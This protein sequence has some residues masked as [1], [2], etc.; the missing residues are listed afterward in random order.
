MNISVGYTKLHELVYTRKGMYGILWYS[1]VYKRVSPRWAG[2]GL[3]LR[4]WN[5]RSGRG[6]RQIEA[7]NATVPPGGSMVR[8]VEQKI[9]NRP[10][11]LHPTQSFI[12]YQ[13]L[14]GWNK[15]PNGA[16]YRYTTQSCEPV[17]PPRASFLCHSTPARLWGKRSRGYGSNSK[18]QQSQPSLFA[19]TAIA[20]ALSR[21]LYFHL[22]PSGLLLIACQRSFWPYCSATESM[23]RNLRALHPPRCSTVAQQNVKNIIPK[24]R[25]AQ[26]RQK[27]G[28]S[29]ISEGRR[30][31]PTALWYEDPAARTYSITQM[32]PVP[33]NRVKYFWKINTRGTSSTRSIS[34]FD[35]AS[36]AS[37]PSISG[38]Y[39]FGFFHT[40][41][42][43]GFDT[44]WLLRV[45]EVFWGSI[46][47]NTACTW[48][49]SKS[50]TDHTFEYLQYQNSL[51]NRS[52]LGVWVILRPSPHRFDNLIPFFG[53]NFHRRSHECSLEQ[54][55]FVGSNW[56]T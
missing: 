31:E 9:L 5:A 45:L 13:V 27:W 19:V 3:L 2:A 24:I 28:H 36:T 1:H 46:L 50:C 55:T 14:I 18:Q 48:S 4:A 12:T 25:R 8:Q 15:A 39:T 37:I 49:I 10:Y 42:I 51:N 44:L 6:C 41:S 52:I 26:R 56:S 33:G 43:S 11:T 35:T 40:R 7:V 17:V 30:I 32:L 29:A 34:G 23:N 16:P 38:L 20:V 22:F 47:L 54:I 21:S 53:R